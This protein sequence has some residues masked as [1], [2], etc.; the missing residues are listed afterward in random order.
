VTGTEAS[1]PRPR[2]STSARAPELPV[3]TVA[4]AIA[5]TTVGVLP[6]FLT[7]G[8][9]VQIRASLD[10]GIGALGLAVAL[11]FTASAL[12]SIGLG[13]VVERIGSRLAMRIA[14]LVG[15]VA[16]AGTGLFAHSWLALVCFLILG[17]LGNAT[18]APAAK[19][20]V[21]AAIPARRQGLAFGVKQA[22]IPT[23]T[24]LSGLA[25]PISGLAVGWRATYV[26]AGLLAL[27][28]ALVAPQQARSGERREGA[29]PGSA[30]ASTGVLV[31]F[32]LGLGLGSSAAVPLGSFLVESAV[33][34][35]MEEGLAGLLLAAG[36][37]TSI[38]VR[39]VAGHRADLRVGGHLRVV[40]LLLGSGTL[41][42]ALLAWAGSPL[43]FAL[44]TILA[45]GAGWGWTGLLHLAVVI[46]N[47]EA[48]ATATGFAQTGAYLGSALSPL[49]FGL[50]VERASYTVAWACCALLAIA[51]AAVMLA[52]RA[53]VLRGRSGAGTALR[54]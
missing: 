43:A 13:R 52:T 6:G 8:L 32:A 9:A 21:A 23:A 4:R 26:G 3:A 25:V 50:V 33:A 17:G 22:A 29:R 14:G 10:F 46:E 24:L 19:L 38:A 7:G 16:L 5:I 28:V 44:G 41:G 15:A 12:S 39:L 11:F 30:R 48:P 20:L 47:R 40:A 54:G 42:F 53:L 1:A 37:G 45:F 35:G 51:A 31:A 18:A 49:A 2:P 27:A 36:S 34:V